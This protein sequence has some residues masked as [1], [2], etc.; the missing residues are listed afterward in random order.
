MTTGKTDRPLVL[1]VEDNDALRDAMAQMLE[2]AGYES[3]CASS[4]AEAREAVREH[5]FGCGLID[6]G[7]PDGSGL[8]LLPDFREMSPWLVPIIL[9]GDGHAD[10]VVETMRSGAF[11]FLTKPVQAETLKAAVVRATQ[12]HEAIR[13]RDRLAQ[14]LADERENLT[15]R[16]AAATADIRQQASLESIALELSRGFI[17]GL[18]A[19]RAAA[20]QISETGPSPEALE[21]LEIVRHTADRLRGQLHEFQRLSSPREDS[22]ETIDPGQTREA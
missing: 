15:G 17:Q 22:T 3:L 12:H 1:V 5:P 2:W 14:L 9:T 10:T 16:V 11:D 7:L 13:E 20:D 8:S 4:C 18:N 21:G 6:L 19:I